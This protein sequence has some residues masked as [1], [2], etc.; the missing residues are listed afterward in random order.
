MKE[1]IEKSNQAAA[2]F[3]DRRGYVIIEQPWE[4]DIDSR[5]SIVAKD[6]DALVLWLSQ[7]AENLTRSRQ[8]A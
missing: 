1:F 2:R 8:S 4:T 3:L 7:L 5:V 6:E